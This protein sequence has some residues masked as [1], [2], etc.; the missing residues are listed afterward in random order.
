MS[1]VLYF[2]FVATTGSKNRFPSTRHDGPFSSRANAEAYCG[3]ALNQPYVVGVSVVPA[4]EQEYMS[5]GGEMVYHDRQAREQV[6]RRM[7]ARDAALLALSGPEFGR[8]DAAHGSYDPVI[9][10]RA[11]QG[12]SNAQDQMRARLGATA[13]G[14]DYCGNGSTY[15]ARKQAAADCLAIWDR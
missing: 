13:N 10:T 6:A 8:Y 14:I 9:W 1:H 4:T 11:I 12:D 3:Q 5:W 15:A 7:F 2:V